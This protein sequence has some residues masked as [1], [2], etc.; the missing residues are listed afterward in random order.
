M[1]QKFQYLLKI[2]NKYFSKPWHL[3]FYGSFI[4]I[5]FGEYCEGKEITKKLC[6]SI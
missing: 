5:N 6:L 1:K 4:T 2:K 3:T